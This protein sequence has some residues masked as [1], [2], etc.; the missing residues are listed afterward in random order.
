PKSFKL[1]SQAMKE[2][3]RQFHLGGH[4]IP[5]DVD[6][7]DPVTDKNYVDYV[8]GFLEQLHGIL[9]KWS[10]KCPEETDDGKHV[11]NTIIHNALDRISG[12]VITILKGPPE[13]WNTF[14]SRYARDYAI[15]A[16]DPEIPISFD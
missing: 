15:R 1:A 9:S 14:V 16:R 2:C 3:K 7:L 13:N 12:H 6:G 10:N 4:D 8:K 11:G 5:V